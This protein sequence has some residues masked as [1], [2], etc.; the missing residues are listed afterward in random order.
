VADHGMTLKAGENR[1][2][3]R[4]VVEPIKT[5]PVKERTP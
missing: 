2:S 4:I 1:E 5:L 3:V